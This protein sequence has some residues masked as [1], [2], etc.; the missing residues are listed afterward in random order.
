MRLIYTIYSYKIS[1][2]FRTIDDADLEK[3]L[4]IAANIINTVS[5]STDFL[6]RLHLSSLND[7]EEK[8]VS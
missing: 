4:T 8:L 5:P 1:I 7:E 2:Y 3:L 6:K